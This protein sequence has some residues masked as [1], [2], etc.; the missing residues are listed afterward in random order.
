MAEHGSLS[1]LVPC[2]RCGR[3]ADAERCDVS[4]FAE[5][6]LFVW[7]EITCRT[8]GCVDESGSAAVDPPD[9]PGQLTRQDRRWLRRQ[10][11]IGREWADVTR[12]LLEEA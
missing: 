9:T 3:P 10:E 7:G 4:T 8:P 1:P 12:R 5:P 2:D 6:G 11:R